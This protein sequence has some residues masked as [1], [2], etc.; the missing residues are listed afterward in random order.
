[1]GDIYKSI[2][3]YI[4]TSMKKIIILLKTMNALNGEM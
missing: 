1:M 2:K 3:L 4:K